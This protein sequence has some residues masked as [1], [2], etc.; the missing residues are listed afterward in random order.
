MPAPQKKRVIPS[1]AEGPAF[2][3]AFLGHP[4][5][6]NRLFL[7]HALF[8]FRIQQYFPGRLL[9]MVTRSAPHP[10]PQL[11]QSTAFNFSQ[12]TL[13]RDLLDGIIY[14]E[15]LSQPT[16][17]RIP[18]H[19]KSFDPKRLPPLGTLFCKNSALQR[20]IFNSLQPLF[21]KHPGGGYSVCPSFGIALQN[22]FRKS[23]ICRFYAKF[24]SKFFV[25]RI[26]A[27]QPGCVVERTQE[28][29]SERGVK[30]DSSR[31]QTG[32]GSE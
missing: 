15:I 14:H 18:E 28:A 13:D 26:Y 19:A 21:T 2:L 27:L 3:R 17:L 12:K 24:P 30:A 9:C 31:R 7:A 10:D 25:Y 29:W 23:F 11:I 4:H 5:R 8:C 16:N 22:F 1:A 6:S 32:A 20:F